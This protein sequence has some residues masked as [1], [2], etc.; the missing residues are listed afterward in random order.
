[1]R[2]APLSSATAATPADRWELYR[3]TL[4]ARRADRADRQSPPPAGAGQPGGRL[5]DTGRPAADDDT[6]RRSWLL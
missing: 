5:P 6:P 4:L 3:E 1:M 2:V